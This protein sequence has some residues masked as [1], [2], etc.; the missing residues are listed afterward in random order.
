VASSSRVTASLK[1]N[2]SIH[3]YYQKIPSH[4]LGFFVLYHGQNILS[5]GITE[6][7]GFIIQIFSSLFIIKCL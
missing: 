7:T 5:N 3:A 1:R 6:N 2:L 4:D